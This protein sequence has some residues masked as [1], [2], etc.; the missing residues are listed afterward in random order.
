MTNERTP[1][2]AEDVDRLIVSWAESQGELVLLR[3]RHA[4]AS[5]LLAHLDAGVAEIA[6]SV[7][8]EP[9][10]D[11]ADV[12][13]VTSD[14]LRCLG[15]ERDRARGLL[16]R[17]TAPGGVWISPVAIDAALADEPRGTP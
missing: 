6:R 2:H 9:D 13:R 4:K 15:A 3:Q 16:E 5:K 7:G 8:L 11:V 1:E 10:A 17:V 12:A 14:R